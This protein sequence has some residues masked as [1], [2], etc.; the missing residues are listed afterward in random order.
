[1]LGNFSAH[2]GSRTEGGSAS[3]ATGRNSSTGQCHHGPGLPG[4]LPGG[5]NQSVVLTALG[6]CRP[7]AGVPAGVRCVQH[8]RSS[9]EGTC[10]L[11]FQRFSPLRKKRGKGKH[12]HRQ[13][14]TKRAAGVLALSQVAGTF[15]LFRSPRDPESA[16]PGGHVRARAPHSG[17][18]CGRRLRAGAASGSPGS[19]EGG[20]SGGGIPSWRPVRVRSEQLSPSAEQVFQRSQNPQGRP[21][22]HPLQSGGVWASARGTGNRFLVRAEREG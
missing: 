2:L 16:P 20:E 22:F 6:C 5:A 17:R 11:H 8:F 14:S 3:Q 9:L 12:T 13:T 7:A 21:H 18:G 10:P 1:M 19:R 4:H 15:K